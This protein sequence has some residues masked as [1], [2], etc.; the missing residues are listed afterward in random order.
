MKV[1]FEGTAE[2]VKADMLTFL[3]T[4]EDRSIKRTG[5]YKEAWDNMRT[6]TQKLIL[7]INKKHSI[8]QIDLLKMHKAHDNP[9]IVGALI[10]NGS[11][12]ANKNNLPVPIIRTNDIDVVYTLN[13]EWQEF[14]ADPR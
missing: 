7:L 10:A 13:H 6:R 1:I 3:A 4:T 5:T 8:T 14:L 11:R 2:E 9:Q 12:N